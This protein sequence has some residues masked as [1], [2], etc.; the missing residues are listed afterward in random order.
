MLSKVRRKM[1]FQYQSTSWR[2]SHEWFSLQQ[3]R[4][5]IIVVVC[6][7]LISRAREPRNGQH[8]PPSESEP[9]QVQFLAS[10]S[11]KLKTGK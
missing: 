5:R 9:L 1:S 11:N 10:G 6:L 3:R 4:K 8:V 2:K 7:F